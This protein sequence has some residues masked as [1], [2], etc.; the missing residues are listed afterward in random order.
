MG[1]GMDRKYGQPEKRAMELTLNNKMLLTDHV[2]LR[3]DASDNAQNAIWVTTR[4]GLYK[5]TCDGLVVFFAHQGDELN[6]EVV[7][8]NGERQSQ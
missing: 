8:Q 1:T 4:T 6:G 3:V 2:E 5:V 7:H